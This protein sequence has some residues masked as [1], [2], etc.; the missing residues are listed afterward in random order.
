MH[1]LLLFDQMF[2]TVY[3]TILPHLP[4]VY[5]LALTNNA[6]KV[7]QQKVKSVFLTAEKQGTLCP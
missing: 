1:V 2:I 5:R 7:W 4:P 6:M 3:C